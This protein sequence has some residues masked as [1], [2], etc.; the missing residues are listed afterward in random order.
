MGLDRARQTAS[1]LLFPLLL[2]TCLLTAWR[3]LEAGM[4]EAATLGVVSLLAIS[5]IA[6]FE[7]TLAFDVD[8]NRSRSDLL[9]DAAH[10]LVNS[11][12]ARELFKLG[13][14]LLLL[15]VLPFRD[16]Q[17]GSGGGPWPVELALPLQVVLAALLAEFGQYWAHRFAHENEFFWRL[18][19]THHSPTRLYW[20]NAGRD[21][22]LGV[23]WVFVCE[24]TPLLLLG[25]PGDCLLLF[26]SF[27]SV[28]GLFQ[29]SN[30]D[31][32]MGWLDWVFSGASLHR[33]HHSAV[34]AEACHNYGAN[35]IL[36]DIVFATRYLPADKRPPAAVGLEDMERFPQDFGGQ[37]LVPFRWKREA[38]YRTSGAGRPSPAG[39]PV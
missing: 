12:G 29:H 34:A 14:P 28:H 39:D 30:I 33:W 25:V 19:S 5:V 11:Y 7:R 36:W 27:E 16:V 18:H 15:L 3:M 13:L 21:H 1:W 4:N 17:Q 22:P 26:Y 8:W 38:G 9:T 31:L 2:G 35:L 24:T 32:R 20:L 6:L 37:M 23:L 10:S